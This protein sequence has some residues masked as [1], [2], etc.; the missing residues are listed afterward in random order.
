MLQL[1]MFPFET[2]GI[3]KE[4]VPRRKTSMEIRN[5]AAAAGA[6][7]GEKKH[8]QFT[9]FPFIIVHKQNTQTN[10]TSNTRCC[11]VMNVVE[12]IVTKYVELFC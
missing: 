9:P 2:T 11:R 4:A 6:S 1:M 3:N 8:Q 7:E 5:E 12:R 10:N